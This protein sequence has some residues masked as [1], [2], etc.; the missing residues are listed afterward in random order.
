MSL[1]NDAIDKYEGADLGYVY[2]MEFRFKAGDSYK[3]LYK[4][5]VTVN[6]PIDRMLQICRSFF[7]SRRY[8]PECRIVRMR[9]TPHYFDKEK[10]IHSLMDSYSFNKSFDGSSEFTDMS[11]EAIDKIYCEIVPK[12]SD[13]KIEARLPTWAYSEYELDYIDKIAVDQNESYYIY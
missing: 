11:S 9:K 12:L 7:M 5:G 13:I 2:L 6:D 3:T 1:L 4:V 8:V 10:Q